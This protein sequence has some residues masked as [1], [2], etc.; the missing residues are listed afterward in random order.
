MLKIFN[1]CIIKLQVFY[2]NKFHQFL[3]FYLELEAKPRNK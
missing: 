1:L 2:F 3:F